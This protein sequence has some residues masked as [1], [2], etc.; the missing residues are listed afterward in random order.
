MAIVHCKK[1]GAPGVTCF[2][3]V[4]PPDPSPQT[5]ADW[6]KQADA[7]RI[8]KQ[9]AELCCRIMAMF[10][11]SDDDLFLMRMREIEQE[12]NAIK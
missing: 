12:F 5:Y 2:C 1:C 11:D 7:L 9:R 6:Q 4:P 8:Q 10:K 3:H